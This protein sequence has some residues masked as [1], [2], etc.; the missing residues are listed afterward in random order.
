MIQTPLHSVYSVHSVVRE[1]FNH[2]LHRMHG[3]DAPALIQEPKSPL[4][5]VL[6]VVQIFNHGLHRMH[7]WGAPAL[8]QEL[9]GEVVV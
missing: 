5:S 3:W 6:S 1:F 8:I 9:D 4:H 7:R 2:G